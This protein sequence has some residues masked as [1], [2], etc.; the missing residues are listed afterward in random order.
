MLDP[1]TEMFPPKSGTIAGMSLLHREVTFDTLLSK[2]D[3]GV[4]GYQEI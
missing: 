4:I 2:V 1:L 3:G